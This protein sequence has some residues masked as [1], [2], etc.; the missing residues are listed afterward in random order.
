MQRGAT[1]IQIMLALALA[2]VLTQV[3]LNAYRAMG[4][5][6]HRTSLARELTQA[7][8][9]AR[10]QALLQGEV[11]ALRPWGTAWNTGWQVIRVQDGQIL[12][13][14]R[15][16]P[17]ARV[18]IVGTT[19]REVRF[20]AQGIPLAGHGALRNGTFHVCDAQTSRSRHQVVWASSGRISLRT[21][22][23]AE[24]RCAES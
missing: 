7:L 21:E 2:G 17:R 9:L 3:S 16:S 24:P 13:E 19:R 22:D 20:S 1:L 11:M 23:L 6:L 5:E 18:T 4:D 8:R 15:F 12:R 10:G 14:Q